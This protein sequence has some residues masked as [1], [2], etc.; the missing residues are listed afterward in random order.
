MGIVITV[1]TVYVNSAVLPKQEYNHSLYF[2]LHDSIGW[3][4]ACTTLGLCFLS[5]QNMKITT[6][7]YVHRHSLALHASIHTC[8]Y[9]DRMFVFST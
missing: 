3:F 1:E 4:L 6:L 2:Y 9:S 8:I 7:P 5:V